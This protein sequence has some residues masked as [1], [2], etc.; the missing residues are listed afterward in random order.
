MPMA[1]PST[2]DCELIVERTFAGI[3]E[4]FKRALDD[5][6]ANGNVVIVH[7]RQLRVDQVRRLV[8]DVAPG[9]L[10]TARDGKQCLASADEVQRAGVSLSVGSGRFLTAAQVFLT[11]CDLV[12]DKLPRATESQEAALVNLLIV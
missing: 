2:A 12:A 3:R 9:D 5:A 6:S 7:N 4:Q 8:V 11:L 1:T 10:W